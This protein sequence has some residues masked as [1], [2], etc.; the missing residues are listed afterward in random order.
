MNFNTEEVKQV[1]EDGITGKAVTIPIGF[2]EMDEDGVS[3]VPGSFTLI[4]GFAG[5]GKSA[6]FHEGYVLN[7][8]D[9]W[10]TKKKRQETDLNLYWILFLMERPFIETKLKWIARSLFSK[11][12]ASANPLLYDVRFLR[13]FKE[14]KV[15]NDEKEL[16]Y[17]TFDYFEEMFEYMEIHSGQTN[18]TGMYKSVEAYANNNGIVHE[19]PYTTKDGRVNT[20]KK[21]IKN[22]SNLITIVG[23][24]HAGKFTGETDSKSKVFMPQESR[25]LLAKVSSYM[26]QEFRDFYGFTPVLV[27][28]FNRS[29]ESTARF[30]N[31]TVI[32]QPSDF[33][34]SSNMYEDADVALA[35]FNA[36]KLGMTE[37]AGYDLT[38][39]VTTT[40]KNR[41]RFLVTLKN[42]YGTD[43]KG[44]GLAF[45]GENGFTKILKKSEL[46]FETDYQFLTKFL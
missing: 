16:V 43:D 9:W 25:E 37:F 40:G 44:Y 22:D 45:F 29:L 27:S 5:S 15:T 1:I 36:Y 20:I 39:M 38:K 3:I 33:K 26:S 18:P 35:L 23:A 12:Y 8:Y 11:T 17:S 14:R 46:M 28:Q 2:K 10:I 30:G 31:G 19:T 4:G 7:P 42:S 32:P 24:D 13:G 21:Y 34:G 6:F 41:G